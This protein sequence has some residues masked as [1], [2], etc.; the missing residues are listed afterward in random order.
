MHAAAVAL[1]CL[2]YNFSQ[3]GCRLVQHEIDVKHTIN[4]HMRAQGMFLLQEDHQLM[5][6]SMN[7]NCLIY[8]AI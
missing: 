5:Y 2:L 1:S 4:A 3:F 6:Y 7:V 8:R